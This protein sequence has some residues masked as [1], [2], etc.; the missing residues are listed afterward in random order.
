MAVSKVKL[1]DATLMDV[2]SDTVVAGVLLNNYTAKKNDGTTVIGN[3]TTKQSS[4]L[5][6]SG[7][8]V[9]APA[10]YYGSD[11]SASVASGSATTPTTT[12]TSNPTILVNDSG[13][14]TASHSSGKSITPTVSAGYISTGTAGTVTASGSSTSQLS[15]QAA[16][17]IYP[18]TTDQ[19]IAQG[20][21]LTGAQTFK[22]VTTSNLTAANIK[23]GTVVKVGDSVDDDRVAAVT[24]TFTDAST[25]SSGQTAA[26]AG[27]ILSGYS[28]WVDGTEVKGSISSRAA[29]TITPTTTN[30]TIAS[31]VY[32][33]GT[34]TIEG[35]ADLVSG[36]IKSGVSIFGVSGS[37][38]VKDVSDTTAVAED[39]A[40]GKVFYS[41]NGTLTIGSA[42]GGES[43]VILSYGSSTWQDFI[44]AY[45]SNSIVYCRASSNSDPASG[46]QTR[47]A[48][49][50]Y[51]NNAETPTNVEFQYYR[52]VATHSDSQQ[53]DQVYVYKLDSTNGWSVTTRNA[54]SKIVAGT[55]LSSSYSSGTL[56]IT[57]PD[58][59]H[60][61]P[62]AP[63]DSTDAPFL[64][65]FQAV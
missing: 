5:E 24:G 29:Q 13:L 40:S 10:G 37:S 11:V 52:S 31:G 18:K 57:S 21:F 30:Q 39:V 62:S 28:A 63:S 15:V 35:D 19:T 12:I 60:V 36:N 65:P 22:A 8:T 33:S 9:T 7:A 4:D 16:Q 20:K 34:Q 1:N 17:T 56:T 44:D 14:I 50:A 27:Q 43:M 53:G 55:G 25:V 48:F 59:V 51:V 54:F 64:S 47:M 23:D 42:T 26:A 3:I 38:T 45:N 2:T 58:T 41:A 61:G 49:M 46:S 32:I 6:V